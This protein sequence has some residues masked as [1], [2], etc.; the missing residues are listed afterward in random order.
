M[1]KSLDC[2]MLLQDAIKYYKSMIRQRPR[3]F[4]VLVGLVEIGG[5]GKGASMNLCHLEK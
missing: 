3:H 5:G 4:L 1:E 2:F